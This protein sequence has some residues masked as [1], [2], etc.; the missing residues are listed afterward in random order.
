MTASRLLRGACPRARIRTALGSPRARHAKHPTEYL[1]GSRRR[2]PT[3]SPPGQF[4]RIKVDRSEPVPK[5]MAF[6]AI[7]QRIRS[8]S[9]SIRQLTFGSFLLLLAGITPAT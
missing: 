5:P 8:L 4:Q 2:L 3:C 9:L 6:A 1:K 7:L